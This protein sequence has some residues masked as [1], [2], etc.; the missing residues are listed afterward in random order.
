M[1]F[2][3][4]SGGEESACGT[5]DLGLIPGSGRSP[6]EVNHNALQCSC[7]ENPIYRGAWQAAVHSVARVG[8]NLA[9]KERELLVHKVEKEVGRLN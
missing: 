6:R 7:L 3:C 8:H 4:S 5:G 1:G 2:P 9:T